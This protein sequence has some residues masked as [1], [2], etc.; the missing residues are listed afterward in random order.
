MALISTVAIP[1]GQSTPFIYFDVGALKAFS[2]ARGRV[3]IT[4][5][6]LAVRCIR[7]HWPLLFSCTSVLVVLTW[8][9]RRQIKGNGQ[10]QGEDGHPPHGLIRRVLAA[11]KRFFTQVRGRLHGF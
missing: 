9:E 6:L 1:S 2:R 10:V 8:Q 11:K 5:R 3:R 4:P 7:L